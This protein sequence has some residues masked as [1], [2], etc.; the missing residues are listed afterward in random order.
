MRAIPLLPPILNLSWEI[1]ALIASGAWWGHVIWFGLSILVFDSCMMTLSKKQQFLYF[2]AFVVSLTCFVM[3]FRAGGMLVSSFAINV[4]M[5]VCFWIDRK[6]L[7]KK[8]KIWIAITK[9]IGTFAATLYYASMSILVA[10]M[11]VV[12]VIL[13]IAYLIYCIREKKRSE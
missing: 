11:G 10:V 4:A 1:L 2:C 7:L 6:K 13:D 8:R 9:G 5:S 12:I 3:I